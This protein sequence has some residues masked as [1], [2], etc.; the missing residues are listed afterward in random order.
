MTVEQSVEYLLSQNRSFERETRYDTDNRGGE[1]CEM[2]IK[3]VSQ[4][5][6]PI[7]VTVREDGC[8]VAVGQFENVTGSQR[9][10]AEQT[11]CVINDIISDRIIFVLGYKNDDDIGFGAPCFS[12]VFA[13]TGREDDMSDDYDKFIEKISKPVNK[14]LRFLTSLKGRFF[15]FN[16]S[17]SLRKNITR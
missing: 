17:G 7:T 1:F 12:R 15:I 16:Y 3:N 14:H 5:S 2:I 9:M 4:P 13:L 11:I 6:F 8:A 10:T